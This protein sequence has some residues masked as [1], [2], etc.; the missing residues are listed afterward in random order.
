MRGRRTFLLI[1]GLIVIV[2]AV[3]VVIGN[4]ASAHTN[5]PVTHTVQWNDA[6]TEALARRACFDCHSNETR[7]L[8]YSYIAPVN[9]L[10]VHDVDEGR[11]KMNFSTGR[12]LEAGEMIEQIERGEMPPGKYLVLHPDASLSA[13]EKEQLIAGLRATFRGD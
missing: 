9:F 6:A 3:L 5:P 1:L 11:A 2:F 12:E 8:W 10:V 13:S 4:V 7:W